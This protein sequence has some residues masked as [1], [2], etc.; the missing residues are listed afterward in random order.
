MSIKTWVI[1]SAAAVIAV[2][3]S[4]VAYAHPLQ[5]PQ[6]QHFVIH[7][8]P[9]SAADSPTSPDALAAATTTAQTDAAAALAAQEA[10]VAAQAA[11]DKLAAQAT[12]DAAAKAAAVK[13]PVKRSATTTGGW[14]AGQ[15]PKGT[16]LPHHTETDPNNGNYGQQTYDDPGTFCAA[17]SG[18]TIN[19]VPVCD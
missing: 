1:I 6:A 15:A 4:A 16:P 17:H 13:A 12:A 8:L 9:V 18:S 2:G 11:A 14:V 19:G 5:T 3:G 7:D 10:A